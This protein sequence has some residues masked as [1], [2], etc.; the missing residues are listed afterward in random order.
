MEHQIV[1]HV[2]LQHYFFASDY[3]DGVY[4]CTCHVYQDPWIARIWDIYRCARIFIHEGILH[5]LD[6]NNNLTCESDEFPMTSELHT[7]R[8]QSHATILD[9][10]TDTYASVPDQLRYSK[11][12]P[13]SG[14]SPAPTVSAFFLLPS[15]YLAGSWVGVPRSI[16]EY[17]AGRLWNTGHALGIRQAVSV[18]ALM[19][20]TLDTSTS[21]QPMRRDN[22]MQEEKEFGEEMESGQSVVVDEVDEGEVVDWSVYLD[23]RS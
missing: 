12:A 16:K 17:I 9:L 4:E 22:K 13:S 18:A 7:Q 3:I 14:S 15:L 10:T 20:N 23:R 11:S 21:P 19:R 2:E 6:N 8:S 5:Q 1:F